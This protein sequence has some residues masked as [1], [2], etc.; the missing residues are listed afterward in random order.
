MSCLIP[1]ACVFCQHYHGERNEISEELP[2]CNAFAAIPDEIFM[3]QI[4]HTGPF[5]G[6]NGVQFHLREEDRSDFLELN[7][8]RAEMGLM[9]YRVR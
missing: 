1:S 8:V 6:D 7:Q 3:G 4:D 5:P 2:S 9:V